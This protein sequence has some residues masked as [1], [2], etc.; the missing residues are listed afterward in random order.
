VEP[1]YA[2]G[3]LCLCTYICLRICGVYVSVCDVFV[4]SCV[5]VFA[6]IYVYMCEIVLLYALMCIYNCIYVIMCV[7]VLSGHVCICMCVCVHLYVCSGQW[8]AHI[9]S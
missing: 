5:C 1:V 9:N 8:K 2:C 7:Y 4:Y 3:S 6:C